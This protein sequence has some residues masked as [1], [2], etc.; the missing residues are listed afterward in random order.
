[1][2]HVRFIDRDNEPLS[3]IAVKLEFD[4]D[5]PWYQKVNLVG[6]RG[7]KRPVSLDSLVN[8][9]KELLQSGEIKML[10]LDQQYEMARDFWKVV[11]QVWQCMGN[12]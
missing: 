12:S 10:G 7:T 3:E 9:L 8:A 1:M 11:A 2:S 5:S 6:L 4:S